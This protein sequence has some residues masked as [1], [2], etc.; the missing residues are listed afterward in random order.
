M[1]TQWTVQLGDEVEDAVSGMRGIVVA[2]TEWL[3]GCLRATVQ[4]PMGE[5]KKLPSS[6]SFDHEQLNVITAKKVTPKAEERRT[7]GPMPTPRRV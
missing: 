1:I 5:D 2:R 4:P 3:N 6:E 7:N